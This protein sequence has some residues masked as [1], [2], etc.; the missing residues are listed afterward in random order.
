MH[1]PLY[2]KLEASLNG[3]E[4]ELDP[5]EEKTDEALIKSV[6]II[7]E[8]MREVETVDKKISNTAH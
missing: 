1:L 8:L 4:E 5:E 7:D 3:D 2:K 6:E